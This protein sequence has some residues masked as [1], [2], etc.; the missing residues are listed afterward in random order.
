MFRIACVTIMLLL[1]ICICIHMYKMY[2][3]VCVY[4][5]APAKQENFAATGFSI[6]HLKTN[7]AYKVYLSK[8]K[9]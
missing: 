4:D 1:Y 9:S 3:F 7:L 2:M 6:S 5:Y 8:E